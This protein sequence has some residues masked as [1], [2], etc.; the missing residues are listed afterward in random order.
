VN[1]LAALL[2][3]HASGFLADAL[4][5]LIPKAGIDV[6]IHDRLRREH[7]QHKRGDTDE[8][9]RE[10]RPATSHAQP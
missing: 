1:E 2:D 4:R 10:K 5:N 6:P 9:I 7:Q 8:H 3:V